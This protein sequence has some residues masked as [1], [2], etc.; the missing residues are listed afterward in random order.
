MRITNSQKEKNQIIMKQILMLV[1]AFLSLQAFSQKWKSVK[2]N[3]N[4]KSESRQVGNF[5]A[6]SAQGSM[7]VVINFGTSG[8]V[9]VE[10]EENLLPYIE[11]EVQ[12]NR[13]TIRTKKGYNLNSRKKMLITLSMEK[14]NS[15]QQSG[16]GNLTAGGNFTSDGETDLGLS[17]SGNM[18]IS[19]ENFRDINLAVSGSGN[20]DLQSGTTNS[21][22]AK[23]SGSGNIDASSVQSK[24]VD[25]RISGSGNIKVYASNS[26]EAKISGSGNVF[27]KGTVQNLSSKVSGSGKLM[28]M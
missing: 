28:K 8:A 3:G 10:A 4:L 1:L 17:G 18:K 27:Y 12:G 15:I 7:D 20:V 26:I 11:T 6:V 22:N 25:A 21:L 19:F 5:T 2:G 9:K 16:S 23:I 24:D 14:I 13:L